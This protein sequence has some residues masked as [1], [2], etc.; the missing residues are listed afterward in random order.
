MI[1]IDGTWEQAR[2]LYKRYIPAGPRR[3]KLTQSALDTIVSSRE[4]GQYTGR[5]L[6]RHPESWREIGTLAATRLLLTDMEGQSWNVLAEY[7]ERADHA[8]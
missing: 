4:S 6:R 2:K 1:V 3:V 7:Q 5:Q 8:A